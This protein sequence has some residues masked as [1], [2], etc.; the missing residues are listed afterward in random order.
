MTT[1]KTAVARQRRQ[2]R[3]RRSVRGTNARPRLC[4]FRSNKHIY[5]QVISDETGRTLVAASSLA[6][7]GSKGGNKAAARQ[8][9]E[10]IA[11]LCQQK[12]IT[13]VVF[14]RNGFLYHGR[15]KEV[16]EG[17]RAAGLQF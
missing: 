2:A 10:R 9:G 6:L 11:Q 17:A 7:D 15:V 4:V 1:L 16:A 13:A 8:I 3:V 12:Q 14:D 5:A